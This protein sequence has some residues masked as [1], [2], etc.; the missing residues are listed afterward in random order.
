M[1]C[2]NGSASICN[3]DGI[4][5]SLKAG[6]KSGSAPP[7]HTHIYNKEQ[8]HLPREELYGYKRI[9]WMIG[10]YLDE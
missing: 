9:Y 7:D 6:S 1:L 5:G 2:V 10:I 4:V 3:N 8:I